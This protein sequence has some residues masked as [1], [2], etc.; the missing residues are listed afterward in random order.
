[1]A[2]PKP[3]ALTQVAEG[4]YSGPAPQPFVIVGD[5]PVPASILERL[6]ALE[7]AAAPAA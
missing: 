4:D 6:A 1:M 3:I 5:I 2:D 7:E